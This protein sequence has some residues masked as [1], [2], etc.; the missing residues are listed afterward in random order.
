VA[1]RGRTDPE[2]LREG[3]LVYLGAL[4]TPIEAVVSSICIDGG[5]TSVSAEGFAITGDVYLWRG[6]ISSAAYTVPAPDGRP[7]TREFAGERLA[8]VVC[9]DR[10]MLNESQIDQIAEGVAEAA[11]S[12]IAAAVERVR[13]RHP[14]LKLAVVTGLGDFLAA[15]AARRAG[16]HVTQLAARLGEAAA[17]SAPAA[18]VA[19]LLDRSLH[20]RG[21]AR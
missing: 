17:R 16:L 13:A 18:A 5:F 3:E 21:A 10:E 20:G 14:A 2:R 11:R 8:R 7:A 12:R 6:E 19:L 1:A 4:R 15:Q 9:A